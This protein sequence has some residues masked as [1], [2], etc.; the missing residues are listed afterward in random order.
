M[1]GINAII[2]RGRDPGRKAILDMNQSI[3]YRGP[4]ASGFENIL[5]GETQIYFG[6]NRLRIVDQNPNSD[7]PFSQDGH[8]LIFNGEIY[9]HHKLRSQLKRRGIKFST[10]SDTEVLFYWMVI[11]GI[12]GLN[13]LHGMFAFL[14]FIMNMIEAL[15]QPAI[16]MG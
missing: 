6:A 13:Q 16:D 15:L 11:Y 10:S 4:D 2:V 14:C 1:C 8:Y 3:D 7:Q 9:N 12:E 5:T